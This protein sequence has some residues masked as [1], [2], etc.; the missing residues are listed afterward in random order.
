MYKEYRKRSK[1]VSSLAFNNPFSAITAKILQKK[2]HLDDIFYGRNIGRLDC[3][4]TQMEVSE[5]LGITQ[6]IIDTFWQQFQDDS[7]G[8]RLYSTGRPRLRR[9]MK[10]SIW[11]LLSKVKGVHSIIRVSL[12]L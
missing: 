3:G 9:R 2:A 5:E 12:A 6:S 8:T 10:T 7:N 1:I 11:K 4:H